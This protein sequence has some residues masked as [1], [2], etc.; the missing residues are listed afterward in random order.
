[1]RELGTGVLMWD[2]EERR[3]DRYGSVVLYSSPDCDE[4]IKLVQIKE[5]VRGR[6]IAIVKETRKS[7]HIG[8]LFH[9]VF[10]KIPKTGQ[11][12][13]LG[14]GTLFFGN[15][16]TVGLQPD[17]GRDTLWLDIRALYEAHA[18]TVTLC[19]EELPTH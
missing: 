15:D 13:T 12:I 11:E 7:H 17:D 3:S 10:P 6:L 16:D 18:Q 14:E 5:G 2:A 4:R 8:D 9:G 19:F 1:M